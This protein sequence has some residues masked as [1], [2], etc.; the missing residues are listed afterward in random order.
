[1]KLSVI[2][3][4]YNKSTR[5]N[6]MLLSLQQEVVTLDTPENIEIIVID[7]GSCD[8]TRDIVGRYGEKM[9]IKYIYQKNGGLSNARNSGIQ[10]AEN[11]NLLFLDD[12]RVV[13]DGYLKNLSYMNADIVFGKRKEWY[14]R[15]FQNRLDEVF[16]IVSTQKEILHNKTSN[17]RYYI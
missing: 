6:I 10:N 2:I 16:S 13:C 5:F 1:M 15:N 7:D 9:N 14:I 4:T 12:D 17:S 11:T 3:P 8:N